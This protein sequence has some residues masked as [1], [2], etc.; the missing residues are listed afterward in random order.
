MAHVS[1]HPSPSPAAP[2]RD[3]GPPLRILV[4]AAEEGG[5][6]VQS[7]RQWAGDAGL[8]LETAP[9]LPRAVRQLAAKRWDV[10][11]ALLGGHADEDL[12]WWVDALRGATGSPR[13][14]AVAQ[15]PPIG[16]VLRA[17]KLGVLDLLSLPLRRDDLLQ[18]LRRV[19]AAATEVPVALPA[20]E[21]HAVGP[22]ALRSE[23]H[24]SE[25]QSL[26]YLVC[27]LLLEKKKKQIDDMN[28]QTSRNYPY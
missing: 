14:V 1:T 27:R 17:E 7:A 9:D 24:T 6:L 12:A 16:L 11:L 13:L 15:A 23:E 25:L 20:V 2:R 10:V 8:E 5:G 3:N 28:Y 4:V 18:A 26:A 19:R 21:H 22:Y